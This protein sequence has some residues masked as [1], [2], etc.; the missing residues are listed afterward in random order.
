MSF[1]H[2]A[3]ETNGFADFD[4][5]MEIRERIETGIAACVLH[6]L[7]GCV[8]SLP[9]H[10]LVIFGCGYVGSALARRAVAAGVRVTALTRNVAKAEALRASGVAEV[11]VAEL[12]SDDWHEQ[13]AGG[14]EWVVNCVSSGGGPQGYQQSY[15]EGMKSILR[16]ASRGPTPLGTLLYTSS[17]SVYP[18]GE[19]AVVS[20]QTSAEGGTP[21][22]RI[23][24]ESEKLLQAVPSEVCRRWFVLRLAGIYGPSRHHLLD[25]LR[26]GAATLGGAGDYHLNL[27]HRDDIVAAMWACLTAPASVRSTIFNVADDAPATRGEVVRW[28]A[29]KLG[30]AVPGFD[31]STG[32]RRGGEPMP[33]RI[34]SNRKMGEVLGWRPHYRDYR[35]GYEGILRGD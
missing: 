23:I 9:K 20:E 16:W 31:G 21:N 17:T 4:S 2:K 29:E 24:R 30:R 27:I 3:F 28:L 11:V 13:I 25:Q 10:Q 33:D 12:A 5:C 26:A 32:Q 18:Q 15:V 14:A 34:I 7:V 35:S 22:G 19:G 6:A 1:S 8:D